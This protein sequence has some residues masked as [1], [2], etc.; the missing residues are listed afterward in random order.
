MWKGGKGVQGRY[1]EGM[2]RQ[3]K[4]GG[5]KEGMEGRGRECR[6]SIRK[7]W[8]GGEGR[9]GPPRLLGLV[10]TKVTSRIG[11]V[12]PTEYTRYSALN[13]ALVTPTS[14]IYHHAFH[15]TAISSR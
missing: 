10:F 12:P 9:E 2:K 14:D 3:G 11:D 8:K 7:V 15:P 5:Y 1:K 13:P 4:E 6:E